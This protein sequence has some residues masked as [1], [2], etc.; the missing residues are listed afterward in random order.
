MAVVRKLVATLHALMAGRPK[1]FNVRASY[2]HPVRKFAILSLVLAFFAGSAAWAQR[3]LHEQVPNLDGDEGSM[4]VSNGS[5][6]ASA[7]V[8]R[9]EILRAPAGGPMSRDE[10][11]MSST[12]DAEQE[13]DAPGQRA[14]SFAPDRVTSL[15]GAVPY[16][17]IFQ[18]A[19]TPYKRVSS[20]DAVRLQADGTPVL[21]TA[22]G[23]RTR[24]PVEGA[25]ARAPDFRERDRFWGSVVLDFDASGEVPLPSVSPES[26]ILSL[27][28]EP[29][30]AMHIER[31]HAD[32]FIA[33]L[34]EQAQTSVRVVFLT[35]APR[36]YFGFD[37][38]QSWPEASSD[39]LANELAPMPERVRQDALAFASELGLRPG[40][41]FD[42]VMERLA[43][44]FRSFE[45]SDEP[46][47]NTGHVYLD[48][49]RGMRGVCRH[50]AYAFVI[51]AQALGI[52]A[53]FVSNEAHAWVEVHLPEHRGW[54]RVDLGGSAQGIAPRNANTGPAYVSSQTDPLPRPDAYARALANAA[55]QTPNPGNGGGG[56]APGGTPNG[57]DPTA[58]GNGAGAN[59][60]NPTPPT[61]TDARIVRMPLAL[62]AE[63]R[64]LEV[65]RGGSIELTGRAT[66]Q[67][68]AAPGVRVE[69]LLRDAHGGERLVG[70]TVTDAQGLYRA[71]IGIPP[72][73]EVGAHELIVRTPGNARLLPTVAP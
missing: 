35:D 5:A 59:N 14:P 36:S 42:A 61:I 24:V 46:P 20:L 23:P 2:T 17:E 32:N 67:G 25:G 43:T 1:H 4:L 3:V 33:V 37:R 49:A 64:D 70:V 65:L 63:Q 73:T 60:A 57:T 69:V 22:D 30:V 29:Q 51:T 68:E 62:T 45:E 9:G 34:D 21:V 11:A 19:I 55:G 71:S 7:I 40:M 47:T 6:E 27:R 31:D 52:H 53:R 13:G 44:H 58:N 8:Y 15:H 72:E 16:F 12:P 50:R 26:R 54:M 38:D 39:A 18:P 28:T 10:H 56:N 41:P 66:T 48:L